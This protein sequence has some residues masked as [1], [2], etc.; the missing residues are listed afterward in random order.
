VCSVVLHVRRK[1]AQQRARE[2]NI[3]DVEA[4]HRFLDALSVS[5]TGSH[6]LLY[7]VREIKLD[8]HEF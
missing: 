7:E 5:D 6:L 3:K 2:H 1:G 4:G 8:C